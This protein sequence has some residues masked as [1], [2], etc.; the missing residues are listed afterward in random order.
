M[1]TTRLLDIE[2]DEIDRQHVIDYATLKSDQWK[3]SFGYDKIRIILQT[4][5]RVLR[6]MGFSKPMANEA[7]RLFNLWIGR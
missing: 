2:L 1:K 5:N 3:A 7:L 4:E 6:D